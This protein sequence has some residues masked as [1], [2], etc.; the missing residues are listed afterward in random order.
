MSATTVGN[1]FT[2]FSCQAKFY[3]LNKPEAICPKCKANQ[4]DAPKEKRGRARQPRD[5]E[6]EEFEDVA[7][8]RRR[9]QLDDDEL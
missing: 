9:R 7:P 5:E 1:K 3:D 6:V 2:C 8:Q 4:K